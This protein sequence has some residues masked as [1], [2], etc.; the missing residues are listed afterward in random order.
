MA[1]VSPQH[2]RSRTTQDNC[3]GKRTANQ[4][5]DYVSHWE[6]EK[7]V[8]DITPGDSKSRAQRETMWVDRDTL[9]IERAFIGLPTLTRATYTR[10]TK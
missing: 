6:G 5:R 9:V 7:L 4:G 3:D 10:M 2:C 1:F 8:T